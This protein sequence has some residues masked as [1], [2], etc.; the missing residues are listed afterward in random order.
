MIRRLHKGF[1]LIELM[2]VMIVI[3]ILAAIA[4]PSYNAYVMRAKRASARTAIQNMAQQQERYFTQNNGY[5]AVGTSPPT[6]WVNY[7]GDS[8]AAR[9]H[10]LSVSVVAG[11]TTTAPAFTISATPANGF[12][13]TTCGA[14]S[15]TSTGVQSQATNST[16][17]CWGH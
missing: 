17:E 5:L 14:L 8:S 12:N 13:D 9:T 15:L 4:L 6:G 10:D 11:T 3:S 2:I 16:A 7:V 1:T